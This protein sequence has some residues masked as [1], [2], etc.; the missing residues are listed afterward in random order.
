MGYQWIIEDQ[1]DQG[2]LVWEG[3]DGVCI[4]AGVHIVFGMLVR[5]LLLLFLSIYLLDLIQG[6][7]HPT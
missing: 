1:M 3:G 2:I 6:P 7:T 4:L 5:V